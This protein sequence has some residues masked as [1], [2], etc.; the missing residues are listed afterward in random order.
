MTHTVRRSLL[1]LPLAAL[2]LASACG[3]D[4]GGSPDTTAAAAASTTGEAAA[5][6]TFTDDRGV[7]IELP[8]PPQRIVAYVGTAAVLWDF[9]VHVM[10]TFGPLLNEDGTSQAA[11]GNID[12]DAVAT[13]G[14]GWDGA[15]LEQLAALDPDLVVSGGTESPW[16]IYDQ[17]DEIE[18]IAPVALI[19]VYDAP[20][21]TI[22]ANY[23]RFA[24][25]VGADVDGPELVAAKADYERSRTALQDAIAASPGLSVVVTSADADGLYVANPAGFPDLLEFE[26][27]GLDVVHPTG[28]DEYFQQLSWELAD[29]YPTDLIL[30]DVREYSIQPGVLRSEQ[31]TWS[32]LPAVAAG[33]VGRWSP[34]AILSYQ[35]LA[36]VY[37]GLAATVAAS[38]ADVV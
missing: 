11:A 19:E 1:A 30:H 7:T 6:W 33:Q 25:A 13:A 3:S 9:G 22:L 16:V 31:P 21:E 36:A 17:L 29:T 4:D 2:L 20:A 10:G 8:E 35:G 38:R 23:E 37:D 5:G 18:Q 15:N 28:G 12:V 27:L 14:D 34:E 24:V 26:A 32:A